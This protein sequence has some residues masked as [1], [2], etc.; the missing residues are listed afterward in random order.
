MS[1]TI[2]LLF[3]TILLIVDN[4]LFINKNMLNSYK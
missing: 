3:I 2:F 4:K 1:I